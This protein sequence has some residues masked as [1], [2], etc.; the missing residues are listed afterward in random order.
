MPGNH[1]HRLFP[2]QTFRQA[3]RTFSG[4]RRL[5]NVRGINSI[6]DDSDLF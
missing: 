3:V 4:M 1:R 2:G 5:V 6:R